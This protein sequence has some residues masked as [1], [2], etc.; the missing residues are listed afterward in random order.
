MHACM[1]MVQ[2]V[3]GLHRPAGH[4]GPASWVPGGEVPFAILPQPVPPPTPLHPSY[5]NKV[6]RGCPDSRGQVMWGSCHSMLLRRLCVCTYLK[7]AVSSSPL[8]DESNCETY[9]MVG[10]AAAATL[11]PS[12]SNSR[13][14]RSGETGRTCVPTHYYYSLPARLSCRRYAGRYQLLGFTHSL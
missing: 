1:Q 13:R 6:I 9:R 4:I 3:R 5:Q 14:T 10:M 11:A 8:T 7:C 2:M 12:G